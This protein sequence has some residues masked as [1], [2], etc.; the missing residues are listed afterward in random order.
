M[1]LSLPPSS[2]ICR[3]SFVFS[4]IPEARRWSDALVPKRQVCLEGKRVILE[5]TP[6]TTLSR[7]LPLCSIDCAVNELVNL[8]GF[9]SLP[10]LKYNYIL[11]FS[12]A[13]ASHLQPLFPHTSTPPDSYYHHVDVGRIFPSHHV[14]TMD[15]M[16][17]V[18][19]RIKQSDILS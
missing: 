6:E 18:V 16:H 13:A 14:S 12:L 10:S 9:N 7:P 1:D 2:R 15:W 4:G 5:M 17:C 19:F 8:Y 3:A 11:T